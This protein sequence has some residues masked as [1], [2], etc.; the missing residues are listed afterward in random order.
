MT[1]S[2]LFSALVLYRTAFDGHLA[3]PN[4]YEDFEL[5]DLV[6]EHAGF[7]VIER[8]DELAPLGGDLFC[9]SCA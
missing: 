2:S 6:A 1:V 4:S 8:L 3:A 7:D 5:L 9:V